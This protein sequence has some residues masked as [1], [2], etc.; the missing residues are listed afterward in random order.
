MRSILQLV[1]VL[2][3]SFT[4]WSQSA[5]TTSYSIT[6]VG[7]I[8]APGNH[9]GYRTDPFHAG[10]TCCPAI[11]ADVEFRFKPTANPEVLMQFPDDDRVRSAILMRV[12]LVAVEC[13]HVVSSVLIELS[14]ISPEFRSIRFPIGDRASQYQLWFQ[15]SWEENVNGM[16]RAIRGTF[17][18]WDGTTVSVYPSTSNPGDAVAKKPTRRGFKV[19]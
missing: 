14:N 8:C 10:G 6:M 19:D 13:N 2:S 7:G 9:D 11:K 12:S 17:V 4:T 5:K 16:R 18:N 15:D 1:T 3:L